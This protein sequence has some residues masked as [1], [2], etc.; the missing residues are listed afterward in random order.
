M[1]THQ[2]VSRRSKGIPLSGFSRIFNQ[3]RNETD[4]IDP[5][6]GT[7]RMSESPGDG[8]RAMSVSKSEGRIKRRSVTWQ[9]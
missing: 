6:I 2:V 8:F 5:K 4:S 7:Q 9:L 3:Y 1:Q